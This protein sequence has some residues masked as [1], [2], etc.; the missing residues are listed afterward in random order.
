MDIFLLIRITI[1]ALWVSITA[2]FLY[3]GYLFL[4]VGDLSLN[5]AF[6]L[7]QESLGSYADG[8]NIKVVV[9]F[10][11]L[12]ALRLILF[13]PS[14]VLTISAVILFGPFLGL[15]FVFVADN[16]AAMLGFFISRYLVGDFFLKYKMFSKLDGYINERPILSTIF[17]RM[18]PIFPFDLVNYGFG[19]TNI[20]F[21]F[22]AIGTV[23]GIIPWL[24]IYIFLGTSLSHPKLL[25]PTA[26]TAFVLLIAVR[27]WDRKI[28]QGVVN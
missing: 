22:Y 12:Y 24:G 26:L 9:G 7:F 1:G 28:R 5:E 21:K 19:I 14:W 2:Y 18:V 27:I 4:S 17:V 6:L 25:L 15:A 16:L 11:L 10:S 3:Y 23:I 13:F 20:R 8:S